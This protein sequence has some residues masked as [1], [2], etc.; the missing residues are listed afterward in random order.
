MRRN[1]TAGARPTIGL[2]SE[3]KHMSNGSLH[4][5]HARASS[6][7]QPEASEALSPLEVLDADHRQMVVMLAQLGE[8]IA[9]GCDL[10]GAPTRALA[11]EVHAFFGE[12]ARR[13]H[14]D[15]E[16]HVFPDLLNSADS[17]MRAYAARL[18]Q[19][20]GWLEQDWLELAPSVSAIAE[21]IGGVDEDMLREAV[22]IFTALYQE[23]IVL[24]E[25]IAYPEARRVQA[26]AEAGRVLRQAAALTDAD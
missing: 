10:S 9:E 5:F 15:E 21:G 12:H 8:L 2:F 4:A 7:A 26:A 23:H 20:H 13:H 25:S 3:V 22:D 17:S 19:D 18:R 14:A 16:L 1:I 24:E 6:R 11:L